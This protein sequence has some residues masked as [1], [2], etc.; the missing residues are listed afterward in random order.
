MFGNCNCKLDLFQFGSSWLLTNQLSKKSVLSG[1][2]RLGAGGTLT[3]ENNTYS[4]TNN[5]WSPASENIVSFSSILE[6]LALLP[7]NSPYK[8]SLGLS[9]GL[10]S[11][12]LLSIL[13]SSKYKN[14]HLHSFGNPEHRGRSGCCQ[15]Q[16]VPPERRKFFF[17]SGS[18]LNIYS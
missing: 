9:G 3:L 15:N 18:G 1:I 6:K 17:F 13:L 16:T 5:N 2:D 14:W 11:R 4:I 12:S 7:L 8:L 10:V